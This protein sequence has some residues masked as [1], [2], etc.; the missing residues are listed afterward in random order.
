MFALGKYNPGTGAW[1]KRK[2]DKKKTKRSQ[3][4]GRDK[5]ET[6]QA[7]AEDRWMAKTSRSY[8]HKQYHNW[9]LKMEALRR[10]YG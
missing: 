2:R 9:C 6:C 7:S 3:T 1:W 4:P 5:V 10:K 8:K